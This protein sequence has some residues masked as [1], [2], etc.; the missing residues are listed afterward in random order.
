MKNIHGV[1]DQIGADQQSRMALLKV[2]SKLNHTH[3]VH[4]IQCYTDPEII[5]IYNGMRQ[6]LKLSPNSKSK[7]HRLI[8]KFPSQI[9]Y[10]FLNSLFSPQYGDDWLTNKRVLKKVVSNEELIKPWVVGTI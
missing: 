8:V 9:V 10:T 1:A 7:A 4:L 2:V 6:E 5:D 3:R